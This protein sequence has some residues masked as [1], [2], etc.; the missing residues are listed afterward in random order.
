MIKNIKQGFWIGF[1]IYYGYKVARKTAIWF[2]GTMDK[3]VKKLEEYTANN[4]DEVK[5]TTQEEETP[6]EG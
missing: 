3:I 1:G 5:E 6:T 2:I 4:D